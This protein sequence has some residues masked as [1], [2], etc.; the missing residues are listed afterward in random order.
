[1][2]RSDPPVRL[3]ADTTSGSQA[4]ATTAVA[5]LEQLADADDLSA[6]DVRGVISAATRLY[7]NACTRAGEELPPLTESVSTTDAITLAC[8]LVRSQD[9]TPF[10][11]AMWFSRGERRP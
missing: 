1:M 5:L 6:D 8:A 7:A 10:E 11:M 9:L 4:D 2:S 3:K